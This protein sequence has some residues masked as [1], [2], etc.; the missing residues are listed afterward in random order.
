MD[1]AKRVFLICAV[2]G[3][4]GLTVW[5]TWLAKRLDSQQPDGS[6]LRMA[7]RRQAPDLA[8]RD[9]NG[10][11]VRLSDF[12]G[13]KNVILSFWASWSKPCRLEMPNL[14][15]LYEQKQKLNIEIL[16]VNFD[17]EASAAERFTKEQKL[18]FPVL[19]DPS[20][21]TAKTF[22]VQVV[23]SLFLVDKRGIIRPI[24]RGLSPGLAMSLP[25]MLEQIE[26][27][28]ARGMNRPYAPSN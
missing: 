2:A 8:L 1:K 19:L 28:P 22:G 16:A 6:P 20:R 24:G 27:A 14:R 21:E 10:Q 11:L 5:V 9:L 25:M 7:A 3:F 26:R 13:Q 23:P 12:K 18:T 15:S 4:A 17:P